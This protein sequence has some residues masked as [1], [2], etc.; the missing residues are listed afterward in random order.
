[1]KALSN[2]AMAAGAGGF[3]AARW[4]LPLALLCLAACATP[5]RADVTRFQTLPPPAGQ[6]IAIEPL[7]GDPPGS[8]EFRTY[9]TFVE[10]QLKRVG[11]TVVPDRSSAAL[12]AHFGFGLGQP[13]E[14]IDSTPGWGGWGWGG[15]GWGGWYG[16]GAWGWPG[17]GWGGWGGP[18]WGA[19]MVYSTTIFPSFVDLTISRTVDGVSL[20]EGRAQAT[21]QEDSLPVLVP[22]LVDA[23]FIGFP[24]TSGQTVRVKVPP[25]KN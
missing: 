17:Y 4:L 25:R 8:L 2:P 16:R 24:G 1:M 18:G 12:V 5:F 10:E 13:R 21:T 11:F 19:P 15:W 20:F 9:A 14:R 23:M 6:T 7:D 3:P 22:Q